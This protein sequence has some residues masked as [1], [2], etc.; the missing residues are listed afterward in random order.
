MATILNEYS[1]I[2]LV[3]NTIQNK[4]YNGDFYAI[5]EVNDDTPASFYVDADS[6]CKITFSRKSTKTIDLTKYHLI[7]GEPNSLYDSATV[8]N[9]IDDNNILNEVLYTKN[10]YSEFYAMFVVE[11]ESGYDAKHYYFVAVGDRKI[12]FVPIEMYDKSGNKISE[13]DVDTNPHIILDY[14]KI[15]VYADTEDSIIYT[16]AYCNFKDNNI[17]NATLPARVP[18]NVCGLFHTEKTDS[19]ITLTADIDNRSWLPN[20]AYPMQL[21]YA[22]NSYY[23]SNLN[24]TAYSPFYYTT[25]ESGNKTFT[26]IGSDGLELLGYSTY[27]GVKKWITEG[28]KE[29]YET[30]PSDSSITIGDDIKNFYTATS[31]TDNYVYRLLIDMPIFDETSEYH[32]YLVKDNKYNVAENYS[33]AVY[34]KTVLTEYVYAIYGRKSF[35]IKYFDTDNNLYQTETYKYGD[36][37]NLRNETNIAALGYSTEITTA[38]NTNKSIKVEFSGWS[39]SNNNGNYNANVDA[40]SGEIFNNKEYYPVVK[41]KHP[42]VFHFIDSNGEKVT[43]A[44]T[45]DYTD[46]YIDY[47]GTYI[48]TNPLTEEI[49]KLYRFDGWFVDSNFT[50]KYNNSLTDK[51]KTDFNNGIYNSFNLYAKMTNVYTITIDDNYVYSETNESEQKNVSLNPSAIIGESDS[52]EINVEDTIALTVT[53]NESVGIY[54]TEE[55]KIFVTYGSVINLGNFAPTCEGTYTFLDFNSFVDSNGN[56]VTNLENISED[57]TVTC[58]W[59]KEK[60]SPA[61]T[62]ATDN[63]NLTINYDKSL[64]TNV[65]GI[66]YFNKQFRDYTAENLL[67]NVTIKA[68]RTDGEYSFAGVSEEDDGIA[69]AATDSVAFRVNETKKLYLL[70]NEFVNVTIN[71]DTT[72]VNH[73]YLVNKTKWYP[74]ISYTYTDYDGTVVTQTTDDSVVIDTSNDTVTCS[75]NILDNATCEDFEII[76]NN[77]G[78]VQYFDDLTA[79]TRWFTDSNMS[80]QFVSVKDITN[81]DNNL[82]LKLKEFT[83]NI[84]FITTENDTDGEPTESF[85]TSQISITPFRTNTYSLYDKYSEA[86]GTSAITNGI[87][88]TADLTTIDN[89]NNNVKTVDT[90]IGGFSR[91]ENS[92]DIFFFSSRDTSNYITESKAKAW[93]ITDITNKNKTIDIYC[94]FA[95]NYGYP[96]YQKGVNGKYPSLGII[97]NGYTVDYSTIFY[98]GN[99]NS[100][101]VAD[102]YYN[103]RRYIGQNKLDKIIE[104]DTINETYGVT[105]IDYELNSAVGISVYTNADKIYMN[106]NGNYNTNKNNSYN[107]YRYVSWER[108]ENLIY[109]Q[110]IKIKYPLSLPYGTITIGYSAYNNFVVWDKDNYNYSTKTSETNVYVVSGYGRKEITMTLPNCSS[111]IVYSDGYFNLEGYDGSYSIPNNINE[112]YYYIS[113]NDNLVKSNLDNSLGANK[114]LAGIYGIKNADGEYFYSPVEI[115]AIPEIKYTIEVALK[116]KWLVGI[117]KYRYIYYISKIVF[118][119]G[120]IESGFV[121]SYTTSISYSGLEYKIVSSISP[122]ISFAIIPNNG[123]VSITV[124]TDKD[125]ISPEYTNGN[126][127][128]LYISETKSY[129]NY[130]YITKGITTK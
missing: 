79:E 14:I 116:S 83:Y 128:T 21:N 53:N 63:V 64:L 35:N 67:T 113:G 110:Y 37:Y 84:R 96:V 121:N 89:I 33:S 127:G 11:H 9:I 47:S 30:Y 73:N 2:G 56:K 28:V 17:L 91:T 88:E 99:S 87:F 130:A 109:Y 16:I 5:F 54:N 38:D 68:E 61:F 36:S 12:S 32:Q 106:S 60:F 25:D 123:S 51:Y 122:N 125:S 82:Y 100:K 46:K 40:N 90:N 45:E 52:G 48:A 26:K 74:N 94:A 76:W 124:D 15:G 92:D 98:L 78:N 42:I 65:N 4:V 107:C 66:Y 44:N 1:P 114:L 24:F 8:F 101:F 112:T 102:M 59:S 7:Y 31:G 86:G 108:N 18:I 97:S 80:E 119:S 41:T 3:N 104:P 117:N 120:T 72:Y 20:D 85:T 55:R 6:S 29:A 50:T 81:W 103:P 23:N 77:D 93:S 39:S 118:K 58:N 43:V 57:I 70:W 71:L 75:L 126:Y 13:D 111:D 105:E 27:D 62:I 69:L 10:E 49:D 19:G 95:H 115:R 22:D 129:N 34:R